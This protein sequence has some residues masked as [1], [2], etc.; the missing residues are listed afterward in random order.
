MLSE[1]TWPI[2]ST[3]TQELMDTMFSFWAMTKRVVN[4]VH[5]AQLHVGVV[6]PRSRKGGGCPS[7]TPPQTCRGGRV[8]LALVMTPASASSTTPSE[9]ISEWDAQVL[10]V[11]EEEE[12][13]VGDGADAQLRGWPRRAPGEAQ[14]SPMAFSMSP[15]LGA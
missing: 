6:D 5:R 4:I 12:H 8:F 3:C 11:L 1:A 14:C 9:N 10:L 15:I 7:G 2:R 13:G